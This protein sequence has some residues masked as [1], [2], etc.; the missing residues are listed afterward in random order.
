MQMAMVDDETRC[1]GEAKTMGE[2]QALIDIVFPSNNNKLRT[3]VGLNETE[4]KL[5]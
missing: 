2:D 5:R 1:V 4:G 3:S